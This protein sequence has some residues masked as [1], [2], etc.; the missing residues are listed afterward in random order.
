MFDLVFDHLNSEA[1]VVGIFWVGH[2]AG[3]GC[4]HRQARAGQPATQITV[5]AMND[6]LDRLYN[7]ASHD[8]SL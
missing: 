3:R 7:L 8:K 1:Q 5:A 6:L 4:G 2:I